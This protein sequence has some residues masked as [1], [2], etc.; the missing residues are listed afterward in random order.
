MKYCTKCNNEYPA[1]S[2]YFYSRQGGKLRLQSHCKSCVKQ[3]MLKYDK[4]KQ[5]PVY[6]RNRHLM[7]SYGI[8]LEDYNNLLESQNNCC[9]ICKDGDKK[10]VVDHCHA[11]GRIR[12]LLCHHCNVAL[13]MF[14]DNKAILQEA[15]EYLL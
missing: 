3:G 1:T 6:S 2:E 5:D 7:V 12:G 14:K 11:T 8:T 10:L 4:P 9:A 13:G 15:M